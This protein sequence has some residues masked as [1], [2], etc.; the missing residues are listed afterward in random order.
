MKIG[1]MGGS[2]S[3]VIYFL[4]SDVIKVVV[5]KGVGMVGSSFDDEEDFGEFVYVGFIG[6][7]NFG[8][9][10]YLNFII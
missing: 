2:K 6:L 3:N 4:F 9:I 1:V 10:C 7:D 8:N 5:F